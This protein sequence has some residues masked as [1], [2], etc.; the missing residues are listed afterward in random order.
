MK[1]LSTNYLTYHVIHK[2]LSF[3]YYRINAFYKIFKSFF[4]FYKL[5][6]KTYFFSG[7]QR[8]Y[9]HILSSNNF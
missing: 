9:F 1:V 5:I 4:I 7:L 3:T 8:H 2:Q 6:D